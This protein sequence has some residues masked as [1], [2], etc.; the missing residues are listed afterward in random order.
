MKF[1]HIA[2]NAKKKI[3]TGPTTSSAIGGSSSSNDQ[4]TI[5]KPPDENELTSQLEKVRNGTHEEL[6]R[7]KSVVEKE[8]DRKIAAADRHRKLQIKNI[9]DLYD[10]EVS[11]L[12]SAR[13][14]CLYCILFY[15]IVNIPYSVYILILKYILLLL[16]YA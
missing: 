12:Q 11:N 9:H 6:V 7:R 3:K 8:S 2:S 5:T 14:V 13:E 15:C 16:Y 4:H 10:Y 1:F